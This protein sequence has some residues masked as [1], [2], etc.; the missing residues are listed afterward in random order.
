MSQDDIY[1]LAYDNVVKITPPGNPRSGG[2]G[3]QVRGKD[4]SFILTN[5]HV[6]GV[7]KQNRVDVYLPGSSKAIPRTIKKLD[8]EHDLCL[9][10]SSA[11]M[12]GLELGTTA[13]LLSRI[14]VVGHPLLEPTQ[15]TTGNYLGEENITLEDE[16]NSVPNCPGGSEDKGGFFFSEVVCVK[17]VESQFISAEIY[18]G[19]SGSPVLNSDGLVVGIV[20]A[21]NYYTKKGYYIDVKYIADF[22]DGE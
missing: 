1:K 12:E 10:G 13:P 6:C 22:I 21:G 8:K 7:A 14:Y 19:N 18:P 2:T 15:I 20:F 16:E 9:L 5:A 4:R 3:F 17:K 11:L